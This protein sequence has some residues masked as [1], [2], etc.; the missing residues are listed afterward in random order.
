MST[1]SLRRAIYLLCG[2]AAGST[3]AAGQIGP[4]T[5]ADTDAAKPVARSRAEVKAEAAEAVKTHRSTFSASFD[6]YQPDPATTE[7]GKRKPRKKGAPV[8][9]SV[10]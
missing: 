5:P 2:L 10:N 9:S 8:Q 4:T 1:T 7:I 3:Q 6:Q